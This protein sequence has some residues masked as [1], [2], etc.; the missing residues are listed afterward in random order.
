MK[1]VLLGDFNAKFGC[2]VNE[3]VNNEPTLRYLPNDPNRRGNSNRSKLLNIC[4]DSGFLLVNNIQYGNVHIRG[5]LTYRERHQWV[6]ELDMR[7]ISKDAIKAATVSLDRGHLESTSS[8]DLLTR[9]GQLG[10]HA[11]LHRA[12]APTA[13]NKQISRRPVRYTDI[14]CDLFQ[15][16]LEEIHPPPPL[17]LM[18]ITTRLQLSYS[19]ILSVTVHPTVKPQMCTLPLIM[20]WYRMI[21]GK[22]YWIA[23]MINWYGIRSIG[24]VISRNP[25]MR[26]HRIAI[27]KS[28]WKQ[29]WTRKMACSW[30]K[31][32]TYLMYISPC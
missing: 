30:I 11:V 2:A 3:L 15:H 5:A 26:C 27:S 23:M 6:S 17:I 31:R 1:C 10:D 13:V 18:W 22:I 24:K 16:T 9:A 25:K 14:D 19:Q 32:I 28:I 8:S 21:D 12:H 7:L 20:W 4:R 29:F